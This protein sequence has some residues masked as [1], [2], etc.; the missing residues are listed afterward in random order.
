MAQQPGEH[1]RKG[2]D[3]HGDAQKE[4]AN[5]R[6]VPLIERGE[7][8]NAALPDGKTVL[9]F[10]REKPVTFEQ[11]NLVELIRCPTSQPKPNSLKFTSFLTKRRTT[12]ASSV[13]SDA[14]TVK[15]TISAGDSAISGDSL[16]SASSEASSLDNALSAARVYISFST[17]KHLES[18]SNDAIEKVHALADQLKGMGV[19]V[20]VDFE[21]TL[22][23]AKMFQVAKDLD[24]TTLFLPCITTDYMHRVFAGCM[25]A[26]FLDLCA[27]E[28]SEAQE[29]LGE[30]RILPIVLDEVLTDSST[31]KGPVG[32]TLYNREYVD[33]TRS[34]LLE[35]TVSEVTRTIRMMD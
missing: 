14:Y 17:E 32:L 7:D 29:R 11:T 33:F 18:A 22:K 3:A 1:A 26:A 15:T 5:H 20:I 8:R 23:Q 4:H 19:Q 24:S 10:A 16:S 34:S 27:V 2:G 13:Y 12:A 35:K 6:E 25:D 31:L 30:D 9:D 28:F 21:P